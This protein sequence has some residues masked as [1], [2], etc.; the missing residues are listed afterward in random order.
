MNISYTNPH[1]SSSIVKLFFRK[2]PIKIDC[3]VFTGNKIILFS[4]LDIHLLYD[5]V[6]LYC[7]KFMKIG[8][9]LININL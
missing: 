3:N 7:A 5:S 1:I 9:N 8:L 2:I 4:A 6:I